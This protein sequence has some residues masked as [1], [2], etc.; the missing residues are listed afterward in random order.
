MKEN[1]N[2]PTLKQLVIERHGMLPQHMIFLTVKIKK[3]PY[4][5]EAK[6][7]HLIKFYD[8]EKKEVLFQ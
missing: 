1:D 8:D 6:R 7:Y 2:I 4:V 5:T 3:F